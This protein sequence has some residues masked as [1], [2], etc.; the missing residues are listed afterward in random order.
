MVGNHLRL[1]LIKML[2]TEGPEIAHK[3]PTGTEIPSPS[4]SKPKGPK[5]KKPKAVKGAHVEKKPARGRRGKGRGSKE[6]RRRRP[7]RRFWG[8]PQQ[9]H[10]EHTKAEAKFLNL[11]PT[12]RSIPNAYLRIPK[13]RFHPADYLHPIL[14]ESFSRCPY[15]PENAGPVARRRT[16]PINYSKKKPSPS[17]STLPLTPLRPSSTPAKASQAS[18]FVGL[19]IDSL[20][21]LASSLV[22]A[23]ALFSLPGRGRVE[24]GRV[25]EEWLNSHGFK[26]EDPIKAHV[27][28]I[29]EVT[30]E[31]AAQIDTPS[32]VRLQVS[33]LG[34]IELYAV[35]NQ[36]P[37]SDT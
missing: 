1:A 30:P 32:E 22:P 8:D 19:G 6:R 2:Q 36:S 15:R 27:T 13:P 21:A 35:L 20:Q 18:L 26:K 34:A 9:Q 14:D 3:T 7:Q 24:E 4:S 31:T 28:A 17:A 5:P 37:G 25:A 11:K 16:N 29:A 23:S 12:D 33:P 10:T